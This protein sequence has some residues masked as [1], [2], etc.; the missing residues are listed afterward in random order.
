[1]A[2]NGIVHIQFITAQRVIIFKEK[3][4]EG[5]L[6]LIEESSGECFYLWDEQNLIPKKLNFPKQ[7]IEIFL[8]RSFIS[9]ISR[10]VNCYGNEIEV[11]KITGDKKWAFFDK[12]GF[13]DDMVKSDKS[14]DE[15]SNELKTLPNSTH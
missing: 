10:K 5:I 7:T 2:E 12:C 8:D 13:P 6:Y 1:L 4:D 15:I 3:E 9:A 11:Y 14:F